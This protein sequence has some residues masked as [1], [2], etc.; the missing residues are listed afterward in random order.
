MRRAIVFALIVGQV[1]ASVPRLINYQGKITDSE[2]VALSGTHEIRFILYGSPTGTDTLWYE[3]HSGVSVVRGLFDVILGSVNPFPDSVDFSSQYYLELVVDG[4]VVS[5]RVPLVSAPYAIR[6]SVA[7]SVAG[8]GSGA[9]NAGQGLYSSGDSIH[10]GASWGIGINSDSIWVDTTVLDT[11]YLGGGGQWIRDDDS[12]YIRP[13]A[14]PDVKVF[15]DT[16]SYGISLRVKGDTAA[17]LGKHG[18]ND[19]GYLG[20]YRI[21][22][23]DAG[24]LEVSTKYHFPVYGVSTQQ[25][26]A[27]AGYNTVGF[28]GLFTYQGTASDTDAMAGVYGL[29]ASGSNCGV[30]GATD[31]FDYQAPYDSAVNCGVYGVAGD[32]P[33]FYVGGGTEGDVMVDITGDGVAEGSSDYLIVALSAT[34]G[35]DDKAGV[36]GK[37]YYF[38][39]G[40]GYHGVGVMGWSYQ[41]SPSVKGVGVLGEGGYSGV[42][43]LG[44]NYGGLFA[45][46][47]VG[48]KSVGGNVGLLATSPKLG[49]YARPLNR[50][51]IGAAYFYGNEY[52]EAGLRVSLVKTDEDTGKIPIFSA[53]GV[54]PY[55][56]AVG[57][58]KLSGGRAQI[59]FDENFKNSVAAQIPPVVVVSPYDSC[60]QLVVI[61]KGKEKFEVKELGGSSDARFGWIAVGMR[62]GFAF[63][64]IP[65]EV[66]LPD[67][68]E[69]LFSPV[70]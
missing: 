27:V 32:D 31:G 52:N 17:I 40:V 22:P 47:I 63:P 42:V 5:P 46:Q 62:K 14:N 8:G 18:P 69:E 13:L 39:G 16:A 24:P 11:R 30:V 4:E 25:G 61:R 9:L 55:V 28:G 34:F 2:G 7:D 65:Q 68:E 37:N 10:I 1:F 48:G 3:T 57:E 6:A 35:L 26:A 20:A 38:S 53:D 64:G 54:S 66:L 50:E 44:Y 41:T 49:I 51:N 23:V 59:W 45:G 29:D 56:V 43:G 60:G 36:L 33:G 21:Y 58:G 70:R 15:D 19:A 12:A 67:F